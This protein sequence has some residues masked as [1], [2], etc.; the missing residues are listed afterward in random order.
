MS[1]MTA[2]ALVRLDINGKSLRPVVP[3]P[4][5]ESFYSCRSQC[6]RVG[7]CYLF[8]PL[9]DKW[10]FRILKHTPGALRPYKKVIVPRPGT[11]SLFI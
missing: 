1:C 11:S 6:A 2:P 7:P 3:I 5:K 9:I 4:V 10:V 8:P